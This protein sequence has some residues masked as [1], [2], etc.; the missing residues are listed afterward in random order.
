MVIGPSVLHTRKFG[1]HM[2]LDRGPYGRGVGCMRKIWFYVDEYL[3][4]A[5][6]IYPDA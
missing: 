2:L 1:W 4:I 3:E 6:K 5:N